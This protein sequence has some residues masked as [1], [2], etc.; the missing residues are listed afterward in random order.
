MRSLMILAAGGLFAMQIPPA[1]AQSTSTTALAA[2]VAAEG[3]IVELVRAFVNAQHD[4]DLDRIKALTSDDYV[5]IS[6]LGDVD[7]RDKM[8]GYYAPDKKVSAPAI[9]LGEATVTMVGDRGAIILT[10]VSYDIAVP[11]QPMRTTSLRA[12]FA[13]ERMGNVWKLVSAQYTPVRSKG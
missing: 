5:E 2:Q 13:A 11:G 9:K 12:V 4:F 6:P 8:L 3:R 10:T 1:G 7:P